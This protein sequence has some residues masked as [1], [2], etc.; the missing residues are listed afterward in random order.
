[1]Q[2]EEPQRQLPHSMSAPQIPAQVLAAPSQTET[3]AETIS[4]ES[5]MAETSSLWWHSH[6]TPAGRCGSAYAAF[7]SET[8]QVNL[9]PAWRHHIPF[10]HDLWV[11]SRRK[12]GQCK[13]TDSRCI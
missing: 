13:E 7:A 6:F 9:T 4:E 3:P 11:T 1:M 8:Q 5:D 10:L 12:Y 2:D